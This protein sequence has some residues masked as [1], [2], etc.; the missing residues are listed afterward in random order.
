[1]RSH[2]DGDIRLASGPV[3]S[4]IQTALH[5]LCQPLTALECRLYL[6]TLPMLETAVEQQAPEEEREK[7]QQG[8]QEALV[9]C[10]RM[11]RMVRAMQERMALEEHGASWNE[12]GAGDERFTELSSGRTADSSAIGGTGQRGRRAETKAERRIDWNAVDGS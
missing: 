11:M 3:P 4:W 10:G 9:E 1:M 6:N 2:L 5:D 12:K 8:I 7:V